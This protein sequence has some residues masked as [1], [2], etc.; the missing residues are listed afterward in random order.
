MIYILCFIIDML[1]VFIRH[2]TVLHYSMCSLDTVFIRHMTV[3]HY[4]HAVFFR[5]RHA[6]F[7]RHMTYILCFIIDML[8]SLDTVFIRHMTYI[9]CFTCCVSTQ[10]LCSCFIRHIIDILLSPLTHN[11]S[12]T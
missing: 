10:M 5:H 7:I 3:F 12:T 8:C 2:M 1:H 9:L 11:K 4:R 6:V